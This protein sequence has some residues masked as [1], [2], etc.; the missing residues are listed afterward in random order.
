MRKFEERQK[1]FKGE[2]FWV[3]G[4]FVMMV[5]L[6]ENITRAYIHNQEGAEEHMTNRVGYV[7]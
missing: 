3:C 5:G 1:H 2:Y 6:E 7:G 4:Y